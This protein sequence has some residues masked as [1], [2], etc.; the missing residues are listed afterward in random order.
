MV[1][2]SVTIRTMPYLGSTTCSSSWECYYHRD[3]WLLCC[4]DSA[5]KLRGCPLLLNS[6]PITQCS[7]YAKYFPNGCLALPLGGVYHATASLSLQVKEAKDPFLRRTLLV[8][9]AQQLDIAAEEGG[10]PRGDDGGATDTRCASA[11]IS[12]HLAV[13]SPANAVCIAAVE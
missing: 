8:R 6:A 5:T 11:R 9:A 7:A 3:S 2:A 1:Q 13:E 4:L 10:G 12:G